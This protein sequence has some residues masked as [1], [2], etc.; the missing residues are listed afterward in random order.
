MYK[1]NIRYNQDTRKQSYVKIPPAEMTEVHG[2]VIS[3]LRMM[4]IHIISSLF[5]E[6]TL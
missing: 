2:A 4:I 3:G 1:I 6:L 5:F